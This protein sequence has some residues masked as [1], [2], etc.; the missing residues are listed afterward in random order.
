VDKPDRH[1]ISIPEPSRRAAFGVQAAA[2]VVVIWGALSFGGVYPWA[3]WPLAAG[4]AASGAAG[5]IVSGTGR[6]RASGPF[7]WAL[8]GVGAAALV[9]LIPLPVAALEA[10]SPRTVFLLRQ[11][12]PAFAV[13]L[14]PWH[15]LSVWPR[16]T[17]VALALFG[18]FSILLVGLTA[19]FSTTGTRRFV[20]ALTIFGVVLALVGI[21]QKPLY[22][23]AIYGLWTLESGRQPF[24]PFVNK[25]HFAGW[26]LMALPLTLAL[27]V[28]GIARSMSKV[29]PG[30]RNRVLWLS[31]SEASR[32]ALIGAGATVMA[33]SLMLTM[34]RSGIAAFV[35]SI[36]ITGWLSLRA[37]DDRPRRIGAA[38]CLILVLAAVVWWTGPTVIASRFSA[39]DWGAFND[40]RGAWVDAWSVARDFP[41]TGTGLNTYWAASLFYQRHELALFFAQAH[42]DY[43]QLVAEGGLLL[44]APALIGLWLFVRD[45][46]RAMRGERGSTGW[47]LRAGAV[48]SLL[49][50]ALQETVDF[51][52]QMPGNAALFAVVAAI[53]LQRATAAR[54]DSGGG[55]RTAG[56]DVSGPSGS[57]SAPR[58]PEPNSRRP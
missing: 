30:W 57:C 56:A 19:L 28:A 3:Y 52:L 10:L 23:G 33:L 1:A 24:G 15:P 47:W 21:V 46:R 31:S 54:D 26:M 49:A 53:G 51:S 8:A 2:L 58:T 5:L 12:E 45:L 50:I 27:L 29:K 39:T 14:V 6:W 22:S 9:Q 16:D 18:S 17:A 44:V 4:A 35:L 48:T 43:L 7:I 13:G 11:L 36:L 25:N 20:E 34:S 32:L 42:N 55:R 38:A 40:R 37:L 41:L